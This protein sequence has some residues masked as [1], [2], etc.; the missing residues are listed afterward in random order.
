M[1]SWLITFWKRIISLNLDKFEKFILTF[2]REF[3]TIELE[4]VKKFG[5]EIFE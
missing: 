4:E 2:R 3:R 1:K 5:E